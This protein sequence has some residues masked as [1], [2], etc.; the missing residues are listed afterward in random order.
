MIISGHTDLTN[1][2]ANKTI[3]EELHKMIPHAEIDYLDCL[4]SD[5]Q[6]DI[7]KE[8]QKLEKADILVFQ[9]PVFWYSMPSLL[10]R[11]MEETFQHGWSH[12]STGDKLKG[13]KLIISLTTG[14][15]KEMYQ[16]DGAMGFE[17]E[18]YLSAI[19][20][21]CKLCQMEYVG[22]VYTDKVSYA[23][24]N[25]PKLLEDIVNRSKEHAHKVVELINTL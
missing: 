7:K 20:S 18:E 21:T 13:K 6:I 3:L 23:S 9:F 24:R 17:I 19:I 11:W 2:V 15:P 10:A 25:D 5:F 16:H 12:G 22:Y 4:Y 1:S 14:A 8:Q